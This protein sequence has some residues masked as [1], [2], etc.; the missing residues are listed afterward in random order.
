MTSSSLVAVYKTR[1]YD[2]DPTKTI[3]YNG[4][5]CILTGIVLALFLNRESPVFLIKKYREA[6]ALETMIKLRSESHETATIKNEFNEFRLMIQEDSQSSMNILRYWY[7]VIVVLLLKYL[8]VCSFNMPLNNYFL[9]SVKSHFYNS[10]TD[11]SGIFLS[12]ARWIAM[13]LPM[14]LIDFLRTKL[15]FISSIGSGIILLFI[16]LE[17]FPNESMF[18]LCLILLFQIF[19]GLS[20]GLIPDI[21]S[22]DSVN[23]KIKPY[24]IAITSIAELILQIFFIVSNFYLSISITFLL[25]LLGFS[26][27][28]CGIITYPFTPY[29]NFL[30]DTS[31][32][33]LRVARNKFL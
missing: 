10:D 11:T 30:P 1:S 24:F 21:F 31:G 16:A 4:L 26:L 29:F 2:V 14:F 23:T 9:E 27:I 20:I 13:I 7:S 32:L 22:V 18:S 17:P 15:F 12:G 5:I 8:F 28:I 33:S 3:G 19:A 25:V 6:E